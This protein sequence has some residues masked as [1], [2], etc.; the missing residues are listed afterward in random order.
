MV[1]IIEDYYIEFRD[2]KYFFI[3]QLYGLKKYEAYKIWS[4]W[5][6]RNLCKNVNNYHLIPM[7]RTLHDDDDIITLLTEKGLTSDFINR[8]YGSIMSRA[9]ELYHKYHQLKIDHLTN[10]DQLIEA[11]RLI[12]YDTVYI[13]GKQYHIYRYGRI[14]VKYNNYIHDRLVVRY[15]GNMKCFRFCMFEMG[16]NYYML[17]GHSFQWGLPPKVFSIV[18]RSLMTQT[19]MFAS[20][21]NVNL[22]NYYSLFY[23]DKYFGALDNFFNIQPNTIKE[24]TYEVNPPFIEYIFVESSKMM[25][26]MLNNGQD[27]LF[28]Y[29]MPNWVDSGGYQLLIHSE[30]LLDEIVLAEKE[31]FYHHNLKHR[32]IMANFETHILIIGTPIASKRW[33]ADIKAKFI[34][35]FTHY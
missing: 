29:I 4:H 32:M 20:P 22:P 2:F 16:F 7:D 10:M 17:E 5:L 28:I 31:H 30:Y 35:N 13:D 34:E 14:Y 33:T 19:E 25:L 12:I 24:G 6:I 11:N 18:E 1:S 8:S 27:L 3:K 21:I 23:I 15:C 26:S 9:S